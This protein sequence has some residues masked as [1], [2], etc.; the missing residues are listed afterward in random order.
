MKAL[1]LAMDRWTAN[2]AAPPPS[3]YPRIA[4]GTL[5]AP[6]RLRFPKLPGVDDA[7]AVHRAYRADYGPTF[8]SEGI[9][10]HRAAADRHGVPDSG[11][12]GGCRRQRHRRRADAGARRAA[13]HLH[14]M[15]PVQRSIG[16]DRRAVEHA[17]LV[18]SA[19]R[20]R[21]PSASAPT[22]RACRSTSGIAT[23]ISTSAWCR[24]RRLALIDQG[25]L[26]AEDLAG[27]AEERR[28]PFGLIAR[29]ARSAVHG[30]AIGAAA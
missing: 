4:D 18:H 30:P 5:V 12:A 15:E 16:T 1:L 26:L 3:R 23:R 19:A 10:T 25:F 2:G 14:R 13:R 8:A 7:T 17:G 24:R 9:V 28:S 27:G 22:I 20:G 21:A 6:D 29:R 11:A